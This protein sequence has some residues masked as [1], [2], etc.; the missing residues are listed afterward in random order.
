M[1][2]L[3]A[4]LDLAGTLDLAL[5]LQPRTTRVFVRENHWD[6]HVDPAFAIFL[7]VHCPKP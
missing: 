7:A 6:H 2:G 1:T 5:T 3:S 4:P